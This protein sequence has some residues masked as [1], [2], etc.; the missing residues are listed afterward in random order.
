MRVDNNFHRGPCAV[1]GV[2]PSINKINYVKNFLFTSVNPKYIFPLVLFTFPI[3]NPSLLESWITAMKW[4]NWMPNKYSVF[5]GKHFTRNDYVSNGK[6]AIEGLSKKYLEK[7]PSHPFLIILH[8]SLSK[9]HLD[10]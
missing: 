10:Q 2:N 6:Q 5:C 4:A 1:R 9:L 7:M 3:T 8:T